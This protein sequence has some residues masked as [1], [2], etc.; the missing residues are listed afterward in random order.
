MYILWGHCMLGI[1][2]DC[3]LQ[4]FNTSVPWQPIPVHTVPKDQ[5][6]VS[7]CQPYLYYNLLYT[8]GV[9]DFTVVMFSTIMQL[10][11]AYSL[12]CP[13]YKELR[14]QDQHSAE[15]KQLENENKVQ[16]SFPLVSLTIIFFHKQEFLKRMGRNTGLIPSN[17]SNM[18]TIKDIL[19]V[20][21]C[22]CL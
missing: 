21:V 20:Q 22:T 3:W 7:D 11:R 4:V 2:F 1:W 14:K 17:L 13:R 18:W 12:D 19:Q 6:N 9:K 8:R 16:I 15:Y 10:L 5:D